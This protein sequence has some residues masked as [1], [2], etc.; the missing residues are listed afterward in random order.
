MNEEEGRLLTGGMPVDLDEEELEN[1]RQ[2]KGQE[3]LEKR[4]AAPLSE[5]DEAV[6]RA[7]RLPEL[8]EDELDSLRAGR[9]VEV[10]EGKQRGS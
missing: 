6:V 9:G 10:L 2:G 8:S 7:R 5:E 4:L 3:T 1:L